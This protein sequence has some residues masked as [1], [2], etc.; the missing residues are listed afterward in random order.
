MDLIDDIWC[1]YGTAPV[2]GIIGG[3]I[4]ALVVLIG[5]MIAGLPDSHIMTALGVTLCTSTAA[6]L[7]T[8][9]VARSLVRRRQARDIAGLAQLLVSSDRCR[10]LMDA[11]REANP[12]F[13]KVEGSLQPVLGRA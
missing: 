7:I 5:L 8:W 1:R 13:R 12:W 10:E 11:Y 4:G 9:L 3:L 6:G 2:K